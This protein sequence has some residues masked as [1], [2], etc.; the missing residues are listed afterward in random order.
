MEDLAWKRAEMSRELRAARTWLLV[1]ACIG[2]GMDMLFLYVLKLPQGLG[3]ATLPE[4]VALRTKGTILSLILFGAFVAL[5]IFSKQ[6]PKLCLTLALVVFWGVHLWAMTQDPENA[7]RG[8]ILKVLF[9][10]ALIKGI[11]SAGRSEEL[12]RELGKVF[13]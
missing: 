11:K 6:K 7:Y 1:V 2:L 8:I 9:T 3:D 4:H 13:E 12:S 10:A 5:W